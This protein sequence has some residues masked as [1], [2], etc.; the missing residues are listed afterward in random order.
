M[1]ADR[2]HRQALSVNQVKGTVKMHQSRV[3]IT[4]AAGG[5][6]SALA[7]QLSRAGA[8]LLL[9]DKNSRGLDALSD[10]L[11]S[12]GLPEPGV[13]PL[14]LSSSGAAE[15]EELVA[16]LE[17]EY[18]GLDTVVHCAASFP[19]LQPVDQISGEQWFECMQVN[20]NSVWLLTVVCLPLL[21]QSGQG[22]V[23]LVH[24]SE[25]TCK[26]AYRGA[27]G[28]SKAALGS[29]GQILAEEFEGMPLQVINFQPGPM[30]TG[31][32]ASAYLSEDPTRLDDPAIAA[33][34]IIEKLNISP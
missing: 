9:L 7:V 8:N 22:Q 31:L 27:Y 2:Y 11:L 26:S 25:K 33:S 32:R 29:L 6:G 23:V 10:E 34:Q 16:I 1:I 5:L 4:G 18:G 12:M 17:S 20:V 21:K 14:D 28:V 15:F 13:C 19:G 24:E 3:L 30:R